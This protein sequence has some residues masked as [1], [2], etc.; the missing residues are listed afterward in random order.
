[1]PISPCTTSRTLGRTI[2]TFLI[3]RSHMSRGT[4]RPDACG[5]SCLFRRRYDFGE[6]IPHLLVDELA[7]PHREAVDEADSGIGRAVQPFTVKGA[8]AIAVSYTHLTLPT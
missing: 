2:R 3:T 1:M 5:S 4:M 6:V 8:E 7:L